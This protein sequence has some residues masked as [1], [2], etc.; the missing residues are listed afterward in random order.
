MLAAVS[1]VHCYIL[2][3]C[4]LMY[5]VV[6]REWYDNTI[7][8]RFVASATKTL[9]LFLMHRCCATPNCGRYCSGQAVCSLSQSYYRS[10]QISINVD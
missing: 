4:Q 8:R 5:S 1:A 6:L 2:Q 9:A 10:F 3:S 7:T